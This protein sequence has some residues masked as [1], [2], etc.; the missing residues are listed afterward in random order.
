MIYP[1]A[2]RLPALLLFV[3]S[4]APAAYVQSVEFP[5]NSFPR[6]FWERELVWLKNIGIRHVTCAVRPDAMGFLQLVQRLGM[7][8]APNPPR[9]VF[10]VSAISPDALVLSREFLS[11][12]TGSLLWTDV[13]DTV[14]PA[15]HK[16]AISFTGEEQPTVAALRRNAALLQHWGGL[17]N[18]MT[19]SPVRPVTGKFPAGVTASQLVA[20]AGDASAVGI[21]NRSES[22]FHGDLRVNYPSLKRSFVLPGVDIPAHEALWLPVDI[23][24]NKS[25]VCEQCGPLGNAGQIVYAT[26]ELISAEYENGILAMEFA[27]PAAGE[28]VLQLS[29]EPSGP[30]IAA[31]KPTNFD[32][33]EKTSRVR[34]SVPA[35]SGPAHRVRIALAIQPPDAS[36]FLV[37]AKSLIIGQTNRIATSYSS[38]D[39]AKR[40]RLKLSENWKM[41]REVKSPLEIDYLIDVP[42]DAVHGDRV[43]VAIEADG[44]Q[45]SHASLQLL[46]PASLR[47]REAIGLH[48]G[49]EAELPLMPVLISVDRKAGR[50]ID[51]AIRNNFPEIRN[52]TLQIESPDL[53]FSPAKLEV[54][55]GASMERNISIRVFAEKAG[56][57][58]HPATV[59]LS[60][61]A[62][63]E[64]P[65]RFLVIPRGETVAY[66]ADFD[67]D[68]HPEHILETQKIRAVFS[69][70]DG[71]R[72]MEFVWKDSGLNVLPEAGIDVGMARLALRGS[73]LTVDT[74]T[75]PSLKSEKKGG[76]LFEVQ[77]P[78]PNR[79]VYSLSR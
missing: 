71:G 14:S 79:T 56:P 50:E 55:V 78:A 49:T 52:Y 16:G 75:P 44:A 4:A 30:L 15:F 48:F 64:L 9:P 70:P 23:Q 10:S 35:G 68:G 45:M 63:V 7:T 62:N 3:A 57:G 61:P 76:I 65:V 20:N 29:H 69:S 6:Q 43:A 37:D 25:A 19:V 42:P 40:S 67:Q 33:D 53:E 66:S 58:I 11:K 39:I 5:C 24:L 32:W 22:A 12:A 1:L 31:A 38:E 73:E 41:R 60:G 51:L 74:A 54:S 46:R 17:L 72:W 59:E 2:I 13:E 18:S 28:V 21:V 26:A 47:I 36:A 34:L 8:A 77:R 27:A